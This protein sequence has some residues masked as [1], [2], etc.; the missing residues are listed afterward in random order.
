MALVAEEI[1]W[2][3][4]ALL[5]LNLASDC[6]LLPKNRRSYLLTVL[7]ERGELCNSFLSLTSV[8]FSN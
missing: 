7:K 3:S 2:G 8:L 1:F 5:P 6:E 4:E